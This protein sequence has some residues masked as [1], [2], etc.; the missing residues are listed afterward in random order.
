MRATARCPITHRSVTLC[1]CG[2]TSAYIT[3]HSRP[4]PARLATVSRYCCPQPRQG[5]GEARRRSTV[6]KHAGKSSQACTPLS[7]YHR[8]ED[9]SIA[10]P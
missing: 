8:T 10:Q 5:I 4:Q 7:S 3:D 6:A 1:G 2:L 9:A